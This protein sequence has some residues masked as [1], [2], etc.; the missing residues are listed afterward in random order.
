MI[1]TVPGTVKTNVD[2]LNVPAVIVKVAGDDRVKVEVRVTVPEL[3]MTIGVRTA[4]VA[5]DMVWLDPSILIVKFC[6]PPLP[7]FPAFAVVVEKFPRT[8]TVGDPLPTTV[9]PAA[10]E[11]VKLFATVKLLARVFG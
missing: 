10:G 9:A 3:L 4:G 6:T 7:K 5:L 2:A 1:V 11:W 8:R